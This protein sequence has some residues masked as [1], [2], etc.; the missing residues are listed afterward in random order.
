M[1]KKK[2]KKKKNSTSP[3]NDKWNVREERTNWSGRFNKLTFYKNLE[4]KKNI[5]FS[6]KFGLSFAK[7]RK[8][9]Y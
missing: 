6:S 5:E 8:D 3:E 7:R 4:G 1:Q 2:K 9:K